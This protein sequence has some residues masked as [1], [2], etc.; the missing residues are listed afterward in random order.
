MLKAFLYYFNIIHQFTYKIFNKIRIAVQLIIISNNQV[1]LVKHTY[2]NKYY[3]PGGG[4]KKNESLSYAIKREILEELGIEINKFQL[5]QISEYYQNHRQDYIF[6]FKTS[7]IS[8]TSNLKL[9]HF[10]IKKYRW[11]SL[12]KINKYKSVIS[13]ATYR[14][15]INYK[16]KSLIKIKQW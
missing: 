10:E 2:T 6:L 11:F 8:K 13:S 16:P 3:F 9:D 7:E 1:L 15:L 5:H 14:Q 4:V 12:S